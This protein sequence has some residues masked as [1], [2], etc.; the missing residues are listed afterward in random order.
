MERTF[1]YAIYG[2]SFDP[3]HIGHIALADCAAAE[4]GLDEIIFMP[5]YISP[6]KQ[7]RKVTKGEDRLAMLETV[8]DFN[9]AF[10]VSDYELRKGGP[11][12]TIET[13]RHFRSMVDG[14]LHF[15]L[16]FDSVVQVDKWYEGEEIL[17]DFPL[18]TVRRNDT[19]DAEGFERIEGFRK[20]FGAEITVLD[21]EPVDASST[22]IRDMIKG[23]REISGLVLPRTEEYIIEHKLYR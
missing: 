2:G 23:G 10:R 7:D 13:L 5:A 17:R 4:C 9:P 1:R 16:G 14:E 11:S 18:I 22:E 6:F 8:L 20:E 12:Y 15:V 21:M 19:D 3:V